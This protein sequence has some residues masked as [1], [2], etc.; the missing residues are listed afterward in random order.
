MKLGVIQGFGSHVKF[1]VL[2]VDERDF[3]MVVFR[4]VACG[5]EEL[6]SA[7]ADDEG[8]RIV[9]DAGKGFLLCFAGISGELPDDGR[10][11]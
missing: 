8:L 10:K 3:A 7:A 6:V 4:T 9:F 11:G 2:P 1:P 5:L